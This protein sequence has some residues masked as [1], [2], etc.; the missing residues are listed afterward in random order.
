MKILSL[1][2]GISCGRVALERAGLHVETYVAYEIDK[3]ATKV[4]NNNYPDI[5]RCGNV[6]GA[7]FLQYKGFDLVMGGFPCTDL[8][9]AKKD[10]KGL[11]GEQLSQNVIA[12]QRKQLQELRDKAVEVFKE[13]VTDY[14][15]LPATDK[16][17]TDLM[18]LFTQKLNEKQ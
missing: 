12:Q 11:K 5:I 4:S 7:D 13:F 6:V 18:E 2:D 8:S 3:Y 16:Q 10:R 9:I 14:R 17:A 1:F 15:G